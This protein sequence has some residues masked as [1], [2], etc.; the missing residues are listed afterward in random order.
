MKKLQNNNRKKSDDRFRKLQ[1]RS[2]I[3]SIVSLLLMI[4]LGFILPMFGGNGT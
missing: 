3:I 4:F 1:R 2:W